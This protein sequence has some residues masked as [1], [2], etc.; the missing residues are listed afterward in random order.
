MEINRTFIRTN[1]VKS[2]NGNIRKVP[3][4]RYTNK[5][6]KCNARDVERVKKLG[7]PP[8]WTE[9]KISNSEI[10]HLQATGLDDKNRTQYIY[11]PMWVLLTSYEKY[12]RMGLFAQKIHL[13]EKQIKNDLNS[14]DPKTK[15]MAIMFRIL[16]KTHI[17]IGNECYAKDNNTYGL[18]T[19]ESKHLKIKGSTIHL[20]F[21]GKKSV[22]QSVSFRDPYC[23]VY[24]KPFTK[25]KKKL[26]EI[27]ATTLNDYLQNI[28]GGNF[29]CKDFRTYASNI[30]FLT[31]LCKFEIP[32]NQTESKNNL[33]I[34]YEQ[35]AEKLGHTKAISKKSYVMGLIP[36]QYMLN[37]NQFSHKNPKIIFKQFTK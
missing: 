33:K 14:S 29:T 21:I 20:N 10:S 6:V 19:L 1:T 2:K 4:F 35:V 36:D 25:N 8:N 17:R 3:I 16:Q 13:F 18:C 9:V 26:F 24:L 37:P 23:L 30:L 7:I 12:E 34:T 31:I 22:E 5:G 27:S 11:H 32:K 28:M 15:E